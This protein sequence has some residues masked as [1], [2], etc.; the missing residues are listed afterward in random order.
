MPVAPRWDIG[1]HRKPPTW[2]P[3]AS[4]V[5]AV[6]LA[7]GGLA[8][9]AAAPASAADHK[10]QML[11]KGGAMVFQPALVKVAP[12]DTA[13]NAMECL[14][15]HLESQAPWGAQVTVTP[16]EQ[17]QPTHRRIRGSDRGFQQ[18]LQVFHHPP[19]RAGSP[20]RPSPRG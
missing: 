18:G 20:G 1:A 15:R 17:G 14:V 4:L 16:G 5:R 7:L 9:V 2:R 12:G 11:T 19:R 13:E 10:V 6:L 3:T 8:L